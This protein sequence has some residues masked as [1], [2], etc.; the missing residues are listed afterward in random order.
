MGTVVGAVIGI[1][2][3]AI[4]GLL[5][6]FRFGSYLGL[7]SLKRLTGRAVESTR[8]ARAFIIGTVVLCI[9]SGAAFSLIVGALIGSFFI[10]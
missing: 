5:P 3:F 6:A 7:I 8:A 10:P 2:M 9:L 1:I 4:F